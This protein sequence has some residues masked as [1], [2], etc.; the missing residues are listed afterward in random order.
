[1]RQILQS[2]KFCV[3]IFQRK[4]CWT[5]T[6][7]QTLLEDA[8]TKPQHSLGRLTC[9][10]NPDSTGE[11]VHQAGVP[12]R[13]CILDGQQRF[14]TVTILLATIRDLLQETGQ[15]PQQAHFDPAEKQQVSKAIMMINEI[16]FISPI[17]LRVCLAKP[18]TTLSEGVELS[19]ARLIPTFCDRWSYFSAILPPGGTHDNGII[20]VDDLES[21]WHRPL[22][23]KQYFAEQL[24][25]PRFSSTKQLLSLLRSVL[26]GFTML[27]FPVDTGKGH[28]DGT[29]DLMVIYERLAIRDATFCKP[30]RGNEYLS[31]DGADMVRNL[32]LGSFPKLEHAVSF[33]KDSW[34][35]LE[36]LTSD[37]AYGHSLPEVFEAFLESRE[38][39]SGDEKKI[40]TVENVKEGI[41]GGKLYARFQKWYQETLSSSSCDLEDRAAVQEVVKAVG[42]ELLEFAKNLEPKS[43]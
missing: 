34:L 32:L 36:K 24:A 14:T 5:E 8:A 40:D 42:A 39:G 25:T 35:P 37:Q 28:N 9:T 38:N 17:E 16:L 11:A 20:T 43:V 22:K 18:S 3:P 6:Q 26:D 1:M 19:F 15:R 23:A 30:T 13:S 29:E 27:C 4:Y 41:I 12:G 21:A 31:M 33:Y 2:D 10:D 7:W